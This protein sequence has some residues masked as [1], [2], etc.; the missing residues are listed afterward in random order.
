MPISSIAS[1]RML[2]LVLV[3]AV[4]TTAACSDSAADLLAEVS[5]ASVD[6][7][8]NQSE[9]GEACA[10]STA[11]IEGL[12]CLL[13]EDFP[14]GS[15]AQPCDGDTTCPEG[16]ACVE[17]DA[18]ENSAVPPVSWPPGFCL[19]QCSSVDG[20]LRSGYLCAQRSAVGSDVGVDWVCVHEP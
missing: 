11:C 4:F 10:T 19:L 8:A 3:G 18:H 16:T 6:A 20:C 17:V 9:S 7:A 1:R 14:Q 2:Q 12:T 5:S 15:C 13:G